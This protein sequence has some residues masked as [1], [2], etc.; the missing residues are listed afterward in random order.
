MEIG[1]AGRLTASSRYSTAQAHAGRR[2]IEGSILGDFMV[3]GGEVV[4]RAVAILGLV[5]TSPISALIAVAVKGSSRGPALHRTERAGRDGRTFTMYKF[6]TMRVAEDSGAEGTRITSG[7]DPRIVPVGR[8][9]RRLK[10]DE[11]PQLLNVARGDMAIVGPRPEDPTI[12]A[13]HYTPFMRESLSV[14]PGL[15][16]PGSLDYFADEAALPADPREA[17]R[18]YVTAILTPKIALDLV[19]VRHRSWRYDCELVLRTVLSIVGLRSVFRRRQT[20]ER[21]EAE[22][23]LRSAEEGPHR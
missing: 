15:T 2:W 14:L 23:L 18:H 20:W 8:L 13:E 4:H 5:I 16:S 12:V 10:L 6:R 11:I 7:R 17:E 3:N 22:R 19:Y 1:F 21:A 9:L